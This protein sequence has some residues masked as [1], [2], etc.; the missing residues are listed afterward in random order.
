[1]PR[2]ASEIAA[3]AVSQLG[4]SVGF[5]AETHLDPATLRLERTYANLS[6]VYDE[7]PESGDGAIDRLFRRLGPADAFLIVA[8]TGLRQLP[9]H[10]ARRTGR[11]P[12]RRLRAAAGA[13]I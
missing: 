1:M 12:A 9:A 3:A 4:P 2:P 6:A 11:R 5:S 8:R 7:P 13:A 10:L